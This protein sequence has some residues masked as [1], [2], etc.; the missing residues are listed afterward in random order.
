[1]VPMG[2]GIMDAYDATLATT[3]SAF[4]H[5]GP[6]WP[7]AVEVGAVDGVGVAVVVGGCGAAVDGVGLEEPAGGGQVEA[8]AHEDDVAEGFGGA[9]FAA[10]PTVAGVG[11]A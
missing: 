7:F 5:A 3:L 1:M 11:L 4:I 10:E 6:A 2:P 8:A 9:L